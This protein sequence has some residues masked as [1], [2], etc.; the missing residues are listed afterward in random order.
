MIYKSHQMKVKTVFISIVIVITLL[1][2]MTSCMCQGNVP[3]KI[4]ISEFSSDDVP[5]SCGLDSLARLYGI[6]DS[7][8]IYHDM[9][10]IVFDSMGKAIERYYFDIYRYPNRHL[11]YTVCNDSAQLLMVDLRHN[12]IRI[13]FRNTFLDKNTTI[14]QLNKLLQVNDSDYAILDDEVQLLGYCD[15]GYLLMYFGEEYPLLGSVDF[16][17]DK[18]KKLIYINFCSPP[19]SIVYHSK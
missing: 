16:Y 5:V 19:G 11:M 18:N 7:S 14:R 17:F 3:K 2:V 8:Y 15:Y 9:K 4:S 1:T 13:R 12:N 6:P 10:K